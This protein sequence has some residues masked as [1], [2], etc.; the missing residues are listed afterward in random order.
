MVVMINDVRE[1]MLATTRQYF[2]KRVLFVMGS[3]ILKRYCLPFRDG[4]SSCMR[5][6]GGQGRRCVQ[7]IRW[8]AGRTR[9][10]LRGM[11]N[12][13]LKIAIQERPDFRAR[14]TLTGYQYY[15]YDPINFW[16]FSRPSQGRW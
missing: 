12:S 7:E 13:L 15:F 3:F 1:A 6:P 4:R 11:M 2:W 10:A 9:L 14:E 5:L 16:R 8:N